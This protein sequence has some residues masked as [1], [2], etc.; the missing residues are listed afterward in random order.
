MLLFHNLDK[1]T[2]NSW[3]E[4]GVLRVVNQTSTNNVIMAR[5]NH[6]LVPLGGGGRNLV[7][8]TRNQVIK[9]IQDVLGY[10]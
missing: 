3:C 6:P 2:C 4:N 7:Q 9:V 10:I 5:A 8:R 1:T